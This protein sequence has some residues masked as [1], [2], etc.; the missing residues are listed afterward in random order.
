MMM[1]Q[2][3]ERIVVSGALVA[4]ATVCLIQYM[5][6][7]SRVSKQRN[8]IDDYDKHLKWLESELTVIKRDRS[9][10]RME[11]EILSEFVA[12][13]EFDKALSNILRHYVPD[14]RKE[15]CAVLEVTPNGHRVVQSKGLDT[16]SLKSL[17]VDP[18]LW[19][20]A[21]EAST[22]TL[23][24]A[25]LH[26]SV[27]LRSLS[28]ED[29]GKVRELYIVPI[30]SHEHLAGLLITS[31]LYPA[32]ALRRSQL[33]LVSR[34]MQSVAVHLD[35]SRQDLEQQ[36]QLKT[37][38]RILELRAI[39]DREYRNP[40]EMVE[41]FLAALAT[42][43]NTDRA[44]LYTFGQHS[45]QHQ[46]Q[47]LKCGK[48]QQPGIDTQWSLHESRLAQSAL[49]SSEMQ[50]FDESQ[51]RAIGI[52]T[53]VRTAV[54]APLTC[55]PDAVNVICLTQQHADD[56]LKTNRALLDWAFEFLS[57]AI[58]R[59]LNQVRVELQ[60]NQD[61]LTQ[62]A[63]RRAFDERVRV[64]FRRSEHKQTPCSLLLCDLDRFKAIN[65][66]YGHQ[67]GD[68]VLRT[69]SRTVRCQ[70]EGI[71]DLDR[72]LIARYGGEE[73]A[74]LLP[75]MAAKGAERIAESIRSAVEQLVIP[76][77][78][79]HIPVTISIGL[80]SFPTNI[81]STADLIAAA[82]AALYRAKSAGRNRVCCG[83][84]AESA[85]MTH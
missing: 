82:D 61:G 64:E 69:V 45:K 28:T 33:E 54:V 3:A 50:F 39:T 74:V 17:Q 57:E 49:I 36:Q 38:R 40:L 63:N 21:Q 30:R 59:A 8:K 53:L 66:S 15:L 31:N 16:E 34:L 27:L 13:A 81:H 18:E 75:G 72:A 23:T 37:A 48:Q 73:L 35:R 52:S 80:A 62:L 71:R 9:I 84:L 68:E 2:L 76:Y 14:S 7:V 60:A 20:Q 11:I 67:A 65:D 43:L 56:N 32:D 46:T 41:D 10:A 12:Q 85:S 55:S 44:T 29:R 24:D 4:L 22:L 83:S 25:E 70:V 79:Q 42:T 51:L 26:E 78:G 6:F 47:V 77:Q 58:R 19:D 5:Y 1:H